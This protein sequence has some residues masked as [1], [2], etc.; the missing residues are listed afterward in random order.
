MFATL[1]LALAFQVGV[2]PAQAAQAEARPVYVLTYAKIAAHAA[3]RFDLPQLG[4]P[5]TRLM[6]LELAASRVGLHF[7]LLDGDARP[8]GPAQAL[9]P[10]RRRPIVCFPDDRLEYPVSV[11]VFN[12]AEVDAVIAMDAQMDL[13]ERGGAGSIGPSI[14]CNFSNVARTARTAQGIG[15]ESR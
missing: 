15:A 13:G 3:R 9:D 2:D 4:G 10:Q 1:A 6:L 12:T 8:L 7:V 11:L 14:V 5:H